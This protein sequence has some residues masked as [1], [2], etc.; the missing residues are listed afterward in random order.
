MLYLDEPK[1]QTGCS[2]L[3]GGFS[4]LDKAECSVPISAGSYVDGVTGAGGLQNKVACIT[5][6]T[7]PA[8]PR[9]VLIPIYVSSQCEIDDC[10]GKGPYLIDGFAAIEITGYSFPGNVYGGTLDKKCP[11]TVNGSAH[12]IQ[13]TFVE[14]LYSQGTPGDSTDYGVRQ[15]YLSS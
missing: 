15:I 9:T 7:G 6:A 14:Y 12:C 2:S 11:E 10:K 1:P 13:G 3:A 8:L 4:Q 5:N